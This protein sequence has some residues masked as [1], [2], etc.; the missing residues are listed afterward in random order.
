M[1]LKDFTGSQ[2][3]DDDDDDDTGSNPPIVS[4]QG[5]LGGSQGSQNVNPLDLVINYNERFKDGGP[6]SFRDG[7]TRQVLSVLIG[8]AKPNAL[9]V[10]Q[11]G[12]GKTKI[13][14]YLAWLIAN[15]DPIVPD[16]LKDCVVYELPLSNIIQGSSLVGQLEE[17]AKAVIDFM[18]DPDNHAI[19]FIDE[20]HQLL[21]ERQ[22]YGAVAQ[23][24]KPAL[25]RGDLRVIGATTAQ[26]ATDLVKDPALS[27]RFT[28]VIVDELT[29]DQ[30]VAIMHAV[31]P[32]L[33]E[34]YG[35]GIAMDDDA[36]V[37]VA[38]L[39][40]QF[41]TA[42]NHRPDSALTLL[43]RTCADAIITQQAREASVANDPTLLKAMRG[44]RP[45][46]ITE[47]QVRR[48]AMTMMT[49]HAKRERLDAA[50]LTA[51]MSHIIGQDEVVET[52]ITEL[53]KDDLALFPR[54]R[55]LTF[56]LAG[57][58]GVGKSEIAKTVANELTGNPPVTLNMTEFTDAATINRIIGSPAGF[59][60]SDSHAELPFDCLE[61][62]P[63]QVILLDEIEKG[64]RAVQRLF[65]SAFDE[66]HIRTASGK[67]VDFSKAIVFATTNAAHSA[68][69]S[70]SMGFTSAFDHASVADVA[71]ELSHWFDTEFLNRFKV[72]LTLSRIE[73]DTYRDIL[74][75]KYAA[76]IERLATEVPDMAAKLPDMLA[77]DVL[78]DMVETTYVPAFGARP[79]ERTVR[80]WIEQELLKP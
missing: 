62:N 23:M 30:T 1:P 28:K 11:A 5:L 59:I 15:H 46:P 72:I 36:F 40:D 35:H 79:T 14:E 19:L 73:K 66:G 69:S 56:L 64:D 43:D 65:M 9:L 48:T 60:G 33:F 67:V 7:V 6:A 38:R 41:S 27:R 18:E 22:T 37:M 54:T 75:S 47:A 16:Q 24:L 2:D 34:H 20:I 3:H 77:D 17:K 52:V 31:W 50:S 51:R 12:V 45:V 78:D 21:A 8:D 10:G 68:G 29:R 58:S 70:R 55:P 61:T 44:A 63:Y 4:L 53:R 25:A 57:P 71:G 49:G 74:M 32:K 39:A 13:V 80:N 76:E 26:E 42:G